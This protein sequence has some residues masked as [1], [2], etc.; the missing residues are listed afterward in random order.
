LGD[1]TLLSAYLVCLSSHE[2][3]M[4]KFACL[5]GLL[6]SL[7]CHAQSA[8]ADAPS[9][10]APRAQVIA[11]E[12][13]VDSVEPLPRQL[14]LTPEQWPL[15]QVYQSK[16]EAFTQHFYRERPVLPSAQESAPAQMGRVVM[17]LQNRLALLEDAEQAVKNLYAVLTPTQQLL[18]NQALLGAMPGLLPA[19]GSAGTHDEGRRS[20]PRPGT[21][22][23]RRGGGMGSGMGGGRGY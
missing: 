6:S 19:V 5:F 7:A 12:R 13:P 22:M 17:N 10:A 16:V 2:G 20:E 23:R 18:A 4:K 14:Q 15:W 11:R 3:H 1:L 9:D 8:Q 21:E